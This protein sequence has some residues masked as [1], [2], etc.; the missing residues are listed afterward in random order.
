[1]TC[2]HCGAPL[3][4]LHGIDIRPLG[5]C[6]KPACPNFGLLQVEEDSLILLVSGYEGETTHES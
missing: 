3:E 5:F 4:P 1:M 6:I 2:V